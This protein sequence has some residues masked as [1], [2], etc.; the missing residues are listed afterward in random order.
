MTLNTLAGACPTGGGCVTTCFG[1]GGGSCSSF[2]NLVA[3]YGSACTFGASCQ[4]QSPCTPLCV[5]GGD[6][7]TREAVTKCTAIGTESVCN[8]RWQTTGGTDKLCNWAAGCNVAQACVPE[9]MGIEFGEM[10]IPTGIIALI[11]A[12][13]LPTIL[14]RK[15]K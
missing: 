12:I 6:C 15:R 4:D 8:L 7:G 11:G 3:G 10:K 14:F 1:K 13:L 5:V 9:F 2:Y